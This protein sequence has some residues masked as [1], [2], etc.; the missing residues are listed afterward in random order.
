MGDATILNLHEV[1]D[2]G[3]FVNNKVIFMTND[4]RVSVGDTS[5]ITIVDT[6]NSGN[7]IFNE[8]GGYS[9]SLD[10][11]AVFRGRLE[12]RSALACYDKELFVYWRRWIG[13]EQRIVNS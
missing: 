3:E 8:A 12:V 7:L 6:A 4:G 11:D 2:T 1:G 9:I 13:I 10:N 5:I